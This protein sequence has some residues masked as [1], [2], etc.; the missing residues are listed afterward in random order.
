MGIEDKEVQVK[1]IGNINK[2]LVENVQNIEEKMLF[3]VQR[4]LRT[5][6][7]QEQNRTFPQ[8]IIV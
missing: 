6:G 8:H 2:I 3:Q 7:R 5:P 4:A 1:D